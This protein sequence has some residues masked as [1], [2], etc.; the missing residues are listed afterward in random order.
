MDFLNFQI[1]FQLFLAVIL[2]GIIGLE[3]EIKR[4][5]AGL[6]TYSL[7]CL[8][9]CVFTILSFYSL[10]FL[11][12]ET[13]VELDPSRIIQAVAVGIGFIGAGTILHRGSFI[14]GLTTAAGLWVVAAIGVAVGMGLYLLASFST[15]LSLLILAGLGALEEKFFPEEK[16]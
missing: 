5:E 7:V 15:L 3:R 9:A 14:E 8:G 1:L 11:A 12:G 10:R 2:G 16:S 6:Q 13:G 4:R